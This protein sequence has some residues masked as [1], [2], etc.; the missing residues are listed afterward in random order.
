MERFDTIYLCGP[1]T[2]HAQFNFPAFHAAADDLRSKGYVVVSPAE[3]DSPAAKKAA[4]ESLDGDASHYAANESWGDLLARDVKLIADEGIEAIVVLP[5]WHTSRGAKLETFVARLCGVPI[6][7]F[8]SLNE[9]H[10]DLIDVAHGHD[11][12]TKPAAADGEVRVTDPTTGGQK[13]SKPAQFGALDPEALLQVALVAGFGAAKYDYLNYM[14]GFDWHLS[15]DALQRHVHE[16]WAGR[17]I[18]EE[19]GLPHMAH[20][21]WQCLC[22]LSFALHDLGTDDRICS[23]RHLEVST[24]G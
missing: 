3:L 2:G 14:R 10:V 22:L 17:E 7:E 18:D 20:A 24:D 12:A 15:Y 8:P 23:G 19:S 4:E 16:F 5:G 6:L 21:T 11:D 13:G 9:V 1:M